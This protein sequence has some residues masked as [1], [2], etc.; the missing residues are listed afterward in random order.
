M[1]NIGNNSIENILVG[2]TQVD[3]V[4]LGVDIVWEHSQPSVRNYLKFTA[5]ESGTFS[6]NLPPVVNADRMTSVSYSLDNGA[7]W[8]TTINDNTNITITTPTIAAGDSVLW[9]GTGVVMAY[10]YNA[11]NFSNFSSTGSFSASGNIMS[12]LFENTFENEKVLP[13]QRY[14]FLKL[15]T[16][17]TGMTTPPQLPA[18]TLRNGCYSNM[19]SGCTSLTSMPTLPATILA[20]GCYESM[21]NGCSSLTNATDLIATSTSAN[22]YYEMF[23]GCTSLVIAPKIKARTFYSGSCYM[24]FNGCS[25][26]TTI[27]EFIPEVVGTSCCRYMFRN[28][29][30]TTAPELPAMSAPANCYQQM[31]MGC[32]DLVTAPS[33]LPA[34][35]LG[36]SCYSNMFE[37][38]SSLTTVPELPATSLASGCYSNMFY[39]CSNITNFQN[40]LPATTL[41]ESCYSRMFYGCGSLEKA[42]ELPALVLTNS[43]YYQMFMGCVSVTTLKCLATDISASNCTYQW[44]RIVANTATFIKNPDMTSWPT[45]IDGIPNGWTVVDDDS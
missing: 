27:P 30:I 22:C 29:K 37:E 32:T 14:T 15:F 11:G 4:Y 19:F 13:N 7:T 36:N 31:F 17:C 39:N 26:L 18:T 3:R 24:M 9:K 2:D 12:L 43:C 34:T 28:C 16:G 6:L 1:I 44:L 41:A 20:D 35:S 5:L 40:E 8:I 23:A 33:I 42:P 25:S 38:C 21:F 10:H 45:G